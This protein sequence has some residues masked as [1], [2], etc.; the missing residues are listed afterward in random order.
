[1]LESLWVSKMGRNEM[2]KKIK[3]M[4]KGLKLKFRKMGKI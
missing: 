2:E 3:N 4:D 1:M